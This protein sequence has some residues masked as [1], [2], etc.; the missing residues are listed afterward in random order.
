[1]PTLRDAHRSHPWVWVYCGNS[2]CSHHAPMAYAPLMIRWGMDES[3]ETLRR[4]ARC[5]V[6]GHKGAETKHPSWCGTNMGFQPFPDVQSL[7]S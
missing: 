6:C 5:T 3:I 7:L 4:C 1:M 2:K